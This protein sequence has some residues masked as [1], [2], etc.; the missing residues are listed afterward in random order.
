MLA[1]RR[2]KRRSNESDGTYPFASVFSFLIFSWAL[3]TGPKM[4]LAHYNIIHQQTLLIGCFQKL[5][6]RR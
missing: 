3:K 5:P 1:K 6:K 2:K 4:K